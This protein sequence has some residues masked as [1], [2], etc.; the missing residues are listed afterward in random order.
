MNNKIIEK[1]TSEILDDKEQALLS[2]YSGL[3]NK[4]ALIDHVKYLMSLAMLKSA[5]FSLSEEVEELREEIKGNAINDFMEK[6]FTIDPN[7][8]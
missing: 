5:S 6:D 1:V 3:E 2:L 4:S 8:Q 7:E